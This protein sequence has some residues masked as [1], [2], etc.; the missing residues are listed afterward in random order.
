MSAP[1]ATTTGC[2]GP[3]EQGR[4][5][6][7]TPEACAAMHRSG[8]MAGIEAGS[9]PAEREARERLQQLAE[10]DDGFTLGVAIVVACVAAAGLAMLLA[11]GIRP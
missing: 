5:P 11:W 7:R 3:C 10:G 4:K 1:T 8:F 9:T 2:S 6:C